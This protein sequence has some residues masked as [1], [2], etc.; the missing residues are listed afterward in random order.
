MWKLTRSGFARWQLFCCCFH[1]CN[2]KELGCTL[3]VHF[4]SKMMMTFCC[5]L[6][7]SQVPAVVLNFRRSGEFCTCK[8]VGY[9]TLDSMRPSFPRSL[10]V[11]VGYSQA[12]PHF[13]VLVTFFSG[14]GLVSDCYYAHSLG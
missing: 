5:S 13:N 2:Y 4:I 6:S 14:F 12:I 8:Y 3:H 7:E 10:Y 9:V 1:F 11:R